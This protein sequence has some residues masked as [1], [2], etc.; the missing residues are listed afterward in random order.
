MVEE[1]NPILEPGLPPQRVVSLSPAITESLAALGLQSALVGVSNRCPLPAGQAEIP[2]VGEPES[3]R[4]ADI[5]RLDP[6]LV[7]AGT[8][9]PR[10]FMVELAEKNIATRQISPPSAR[11]AVADLR[12]LVLLFASPSALQSVVWLD[13]SLDWLEQSRPEKPVRV[14]CP[15]AR[16]GAAEDPAAWK[17]IAGGTYAAD[18]LSLCGA[19]NIFPSGDSVSRAMLA[20]AAPE[21]ILL[22]GDPFPFSEA[23]A[24]GIRGVLPELPAVRGER[25]HWMDGRDLFWPGTRIGNA[26]RLLPGLVFSL[27]SVGRKDRR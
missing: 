4:L 27:R 22:P 3:P 16:E 23:D 26:I 24:A 17:S 2:R 21:L 1:M 15:V 20:D 11:R 19:E 5:I 9:N 13:R 6:D 12:D 10:L 25:V 14:F 8:E 7:L 18:L